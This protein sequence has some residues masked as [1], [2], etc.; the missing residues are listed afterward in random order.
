M[1]PF[2]YR[3]CHITDFDEDALRG[4]MSGR[5]SERDDPRVSTNNPQDSRGDLMQPTNARAFSR[6]IINVPEVSGATPTLNPG[7]E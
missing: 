3:P 5:T 7:Q 6:A 1:Q 2:R 4:T